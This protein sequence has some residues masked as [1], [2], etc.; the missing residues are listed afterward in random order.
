MTIIKNLAAYTDYPFEAIA[1]LAYA[2]LA[3]AIQTL[4]KQSQGITTSALK[5]LECFLQITDQQLSLDDL[6][7]SRLDE[8][9]RGVVGAIYSPSF[10]SAISRHRYAQ[11]RKLFKAFTALKSLDHRFHQPANITFSTAQH[12]KDVAECIAHFENLPRN[13]NKVRIW[14]G[15]PTTNKAGETHWLSLYNINKRLG[16]VFC[17]RLFGACNNYFSSRRDIRVPCISDLDKFIGQYS[18][19]I[20]AEKFFDH[21]FLTEFWRNFFVYY[22]ESNHN[23]GKGAKL[24]TLIARWRNQFMSFVDEYL[25]TP[26]IIVKTYSAF[27]SPEPRKTYGA[28]TNLTTTSDGIRIKTKLLTPIPLQ[29]SND[30]AFDIL[31]RQIREDFSA[32]IQWAEHQASEHWRCYQQRLESNGRGTPRFVQERGCNEAGHRWLTNRSNPEC[33]DNLVATFNHHG[34]VTRADI[35]VTVIYPAPLTQTAYELAFP[36]RLTLLPHCAI[37]IA[38]HPEITESFLTKLCLYDKYGNISGYI[39]SD[40][41]AKLIGN[42]YRKGKVHAQQSIV[43][44]DKTRIIVEQIIALTQPLRDYLRK[45]GD[46][47]WRNLLLSCGKGFEYPSTIKNMWVSVNNKSS[48]PFFL[49]NLENDLLPYLNESLPRAERLIKNF[50]LSALRAT[51][52]VIVFLDTGSVDKMAKALG[53]TRYI[54]SLISHY[55]PEP[56]LAYFQERWIRQFQTGIIVE[57]MKDSEHLLEA[58]DF[59]SMEALD[60]FLKL[61]ALKNIPKHLESPDWTVEHSSNQINDSCNEVVFGVSTGILTALMSIQK[62]VKESQ[63]PVASSALYWSEIGKRLCGYIKTNLHHR[64]D[65]QEQLQL[66]LVA[67][68]SSLVEKIIYEKP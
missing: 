35:D 64:P 5:I 44:N 32:V 62:A 2:E 8:V 60:N 7:T 9:C 12:S 18:G 14:Q 33:F 6:K 58:S 37:L 49:R 20:S 61:H 10:Y 45:K 68:N 38:N 65:L 25:I 11:A 17:E 4:P 46:D 26:G 67:A 57:A 41:G 28:K 54:P 3:K 21:N 63:R 23:G 30:E 42:K 24:D 40:G 29:F 53:H 27:P 48:R 55:L 16:S 34:Y 31:F 1:P 19:E 43:L 50:S 22:L 39:L 36:T 47:T 56:I 66:A 59:E 52:G 13:G 51:A 15:W